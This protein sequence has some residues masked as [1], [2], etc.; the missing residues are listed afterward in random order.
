MYVHVPCVF[1]MPSEARRVFDP[2]ELELQMAVSHPVGAG[3]RT[4]VLWKSNQ[5]SK[6]L[7][8]FSSLL[9]K[10]TCKVAFPQALVPLSM[11]K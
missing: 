9:T 1:L 8:H 4:H 5:C 6:L 2:L 11:E 7:S 3:N 10:V